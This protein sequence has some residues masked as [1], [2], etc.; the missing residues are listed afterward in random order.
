MSMEELFQNKVIRPVIK[1]LHKILLLALAAYLQ[2]KNVKFEQKA[3]SEKM[4]YLSSAISK[5]I[6]FRNM[7]TGMVAGNLS[8]DE[9]STYL[10]LNSSDINKRIL[11]ILTERFRS[12]HEEITLLLNKPL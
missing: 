10:S 8:D 5:D 11:C 6:A 7:L 9:F 12:S 2:N 3:E 4:D 1:E